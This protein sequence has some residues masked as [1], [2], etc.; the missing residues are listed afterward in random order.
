MISQGRSPLMQTAIP[1][2]LYPQA[3]LW[4][5]IHTCAVKKQFCTYMRSGGDNIVKT[6][7]SPFRVPE[8]NCQNQ[9]RINKG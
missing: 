6:V 4:S 1:T 7:G 5:A 9:D 3:A 2:L 8:T